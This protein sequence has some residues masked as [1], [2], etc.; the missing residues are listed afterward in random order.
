MI[1]RVAYFDGLTQEQI[2][3]QDENWLRRFGPAITSQPGLVALFHLAQP[4]G[5]RLSFSIWESKQ[6]MEAGGRR[7]NAEPLLPG[8]R[9][10]DIPG[11]SRV[12]VL[13]V[14]HHFIGAPAVA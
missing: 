7:A 4:D 3:T 8:Q 11:P 12:E 2:E 14:Q 5:G 9:G 13:E 10:E 6:A 1:A